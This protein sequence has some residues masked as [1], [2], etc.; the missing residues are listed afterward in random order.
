M[1]RIPRPSL[2]TLPAFAVRVRRVLHQHL[3]T[4]TRHEEPTTLISYMNAFFISNLAPSMCLL[5]KNET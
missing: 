4:P 1:A 2:Q 5:A 3:P